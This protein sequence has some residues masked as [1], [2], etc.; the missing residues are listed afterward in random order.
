MFKDGEVF[1]K[2]CSVS[3]NYCDFEGML[4]I[5]FM[6]LIVSYYDWVLILNVCFYSM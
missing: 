5:L 2:I 3:F 1:V 6:V 4:Q